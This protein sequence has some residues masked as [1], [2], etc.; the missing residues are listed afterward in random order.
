M[1]F[2]RGCIIKR[3]C[4][5]VSQAVSYFAKMMDKDGKV[6]FQYVIDQSKVLKLKV[7]SRHI[8]GPAYRSFLRCRPN[9]VGVSGLTYHT[10][11]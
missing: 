9:S 3:K 7:P 11:E 6:K 5:I 8:P 10:C 1:K 2:C 4:R